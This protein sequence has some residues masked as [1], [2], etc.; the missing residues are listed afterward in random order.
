MALKDS[1][2]GSGRTPGVCTGMPKQFL[3]LEVPREDKFKKSVCEELSSLYSQQVGSPSRTETE[4]VQEDDTKATDEKKTWCDEGAKHALQK[5]GY[6]ISVVLKSPVVKDA[7]HIYTQTEVFKIENSFNVQ[8]AYHPEPLCAEKTWLDAHQMELPLDNLAGSSAR[9]IEFVPTVPYR[10]KIEVLNQNDSV[11]GTSDAHSASISERSMCSH[12]PAPAQRIKL[13]TKDCNNI[14]N[15]DGRIVRTCDLLTIDRQCE[16]MEVTIKFF[17]HSESSH[18]IRIQRTWAAKTVA[19][20]PPAP[21]EGIVSTI[22]TTLVLQLKDEAIALAGFWVYSQVNSLVSQLNPQPQPKVATSKQ[23]SPQ[24]NVQWQL[25]LRS[26]VNFPN[27]LALVCSGKFCD[28]WQNF[29][30]MDGWDKGW[31]IL[32]LAVDKARM[33]CL[34][35]TSGTSDSVKPQQDLATKIM[36]AYSTR[37]NRPGHK[38]ISTLYHFPRG[39]EDSQTANC[40]LQLGNKPWPSTESYPQHQWTPTNL[41]WSI[42]LEGRWAAQPRKTGLVPKIELTG[43]ED[44]GACVHNCIKL[45]FV[46][47]NSNYGC[48]QSYGVKFLG[49][50]AKR[51]FFQSSKTD[52]LSN[53]ASPLYWS[54]RLGARCELDAFV[55]EEAANKY[56]QKKKAVVLRVFHPYGATLGFNKHATIRYSLFAKNDHPAAIETEIHH[57]GQFP[58]EDVCCKKNRKKS[59][60]KECAS[61]K[62]IKEDLVKKRMHPMSQHSHPTQDGTYVRIIAV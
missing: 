4:M 57:S 20:A 31:K 16:K 24:P 33:L 54:Q 6:Y 48:I 25:S 12:E 7:G 32:G 42:P 39:F 53:G 56:S 60:N 35:G 11:K 62:Q 36:R 55:D 28:Q 2:S 15:V 52:G 26:V 49:R 10:F 58:Q 21:F 38:I 50:V 46:R 34:H 18:K 8:F 23:C 40:R 19:G 44:E 13:I 51:I 22:G 30:A 27:V 43:C 17:E 3:S 14:D 61:W 1:P 47:P 5:F 9:E 45:T 59:T 29:V 41:A 37:I